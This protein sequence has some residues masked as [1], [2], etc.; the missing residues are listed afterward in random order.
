MTSKQGYGKVL[1]VAASA[2]IIVPYE[3]TGTSLS[4]ML[5]GSDAVMLKEIDN[6]S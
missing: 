1:Q 4:L 6:I 2:Y 3:D 5:Y